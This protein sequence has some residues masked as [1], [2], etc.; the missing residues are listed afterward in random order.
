MLRGFDNFEILMSLVIGGLILCGLAL[1]ISSKMKKIKD[2]MYHI[3]TLDLDVKMA[4]N[5][6]S[7]KTKK[8]VRDYWFII[9]VVTVVVIFFLF[10]YF[11][12]RNLSPDNDWLYLMVIIGL[13]YKFFKKD[14]WG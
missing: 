13:I 10:W 7:E 4:F 1:Y 11:F 8:R 14:L 2:F 5:K 12:S 9:K 6:L 3:V